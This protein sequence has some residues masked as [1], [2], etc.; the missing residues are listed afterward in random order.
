MIRSIQVVLIVFFMTFSVVSLSI[1]APVGDFGNG[2]GYVDQLEKN[3]EEGTEQILK[4]PER[5]EPTYAESK[6]TTWELPAADHLQSFFLSIIN[7]ADST[8]RG[9]W[10][11]LTAPIPIAQKAQPNVA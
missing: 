4:S 6:H 10:K 1:A 5:I 3:L 7:V 2:L 8:C 11:V 9:L